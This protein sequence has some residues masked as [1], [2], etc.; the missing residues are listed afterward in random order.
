MGIIRAVLMLLEA[1]AEAIKAVRFN[2]L[3]GVV[4]AAKNKDQKAI[5][6]LNNIADK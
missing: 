6:D 2:R 3:K 5:D 1:I 4:D